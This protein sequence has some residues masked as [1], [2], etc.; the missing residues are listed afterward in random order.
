VDVFRVLVFNIFTVLFD[1]NIFE[2]L[3][4]FTTCPKVVEKVENAKFNV[5]ITTVD[6]PVIVLNTWG[7]LISELVAV[8]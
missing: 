8:E 6:I 1:N 3:L 4:V 2:K 5:E 7:I